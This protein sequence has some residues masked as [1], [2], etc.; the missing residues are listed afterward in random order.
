MAGNIVNNR[1]GEQIAQAVAAGLAVADVGGGDGQRGHVELHEGT[2]RRLPQGVGPGPAGGDDINSGER[3]GGRL[4]LT[5]G[6]S[7]A[8]IK[9]IVEG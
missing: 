6:V 3:Y 4:A 1:R 8:S 9:I 7:P 5:F 2:V